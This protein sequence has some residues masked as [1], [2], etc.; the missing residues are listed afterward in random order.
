MLIIPTEII[1]F[2]FLFH[3][4]LSVGFNLDINA[5]STLTNLFYYYYFPRIINIVFKLY[6]TIFLKERR[7]RRKKKN[8]L[9]KKRKKTL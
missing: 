9:V 3:L 7:K 6:R 4:P 8:N 5:D 2:I 1:F